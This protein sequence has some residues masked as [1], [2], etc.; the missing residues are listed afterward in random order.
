M[1]LPRRR[2]SPCPK[3]PRR[4]ARKPSCSKPEESPPKSFQSSSRLQRKATAPSAL[5]RAP[6]QPQLLPSPTLNLPSPIYPPQKLRS[7]F[8]IRRFRESASGDLRLII[9]ISVGRHLDRLF[10]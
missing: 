2:Q 9:S 8:C 6:S 4:T 5:S 1:H 7:R 10:H 3:H